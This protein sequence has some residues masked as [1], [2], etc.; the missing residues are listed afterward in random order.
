[1]FLRKRRNFLGKRHCVIGLVSRIHAQRERTGHLSLRFFPGLRRPSEIV[2]W[3]FRFFMRLVIASAAW[4]SHLTYIAYLVTS[5]IVRK[6]SISKELCKIFFI[7]C[8]T[9][10]LK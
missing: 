1:M 3:V 5:E 8:L 10:I 4:Q 7:L 6:Y 9:I 2:R